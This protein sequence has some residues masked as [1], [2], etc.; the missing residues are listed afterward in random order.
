MSPRLAQLVDPVRYLG[1]RMF[2]KKVI[3]HQDMKTDLIRCLSTVQLMFLGIGNTIGVG[4]YVLLGEITREHA[5]NII[6][7]AIFIFVYIWRDS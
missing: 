1:S 3:D 4:I 5:G 6:M 7:H 2:Q